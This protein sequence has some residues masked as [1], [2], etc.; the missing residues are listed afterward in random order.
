M[1]VVKG[2]AYGHGLQQVA[3]LCDKS[4]G[5]DALCVVSLSEALELI[6]LGIQKPILIL[7]IYDFD[8]KRLSRAISKNVAFPLYTLEQAKVLSKL[9]KKLSKPVR[10]H[11]KIDT[12]ASRIGLVPHEALSFV[13]HVSSS[14]PQLVL[15][16]IWS[17]YASSESDKRYTD[18]QTKIFQNVVAHLKDNGFSI[19][20]QHIACSASAIL[21]P[22]TAGN[23]LR[24][25]ISLYGLYS[26]QHPVKSIKLKAA[27]SWHTTV[28]Q[29]K[30]LSAGTKISYGGTFTTKRA[31]KLAVLPVGY[32][33][34]LPRALSNIG[35]VLINGVRCPIRGRVCMNLTMV[36]V[37]A[38]GSVKAGDRV[39]LIG[40]YGKATIQAEELA[41]Q[42][43]TIHYEIVTR[44]NPLIT[45]FVLP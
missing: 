16:G 40:T 30:H 36:D 8:T 9:A 29:V 34:G 23:A 38:A 44:I 33:D 26:T 45:R 20:V 39:V 37:T 14:Y 19:P 28:M 12:G 1:T 42:A 18:Q 35:S 21:K 13:R 25:G 17:H 4:R 11:I 31:T 5:V 22:N 2:N 32:A 3:A 43:G 6:D 41:K 24:L 7:A 15:E 27:L 10:V